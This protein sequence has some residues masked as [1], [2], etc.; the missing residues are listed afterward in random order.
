MM[1]YMMLYLG[2]AMWLSAAVASIAEPTALTDMMF[3]G[4]AILAFIGHAVHRVA[5]AIENNGHASTKT[6]SKP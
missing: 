1:K 2:W 6:A 5:D 3:G 4:L